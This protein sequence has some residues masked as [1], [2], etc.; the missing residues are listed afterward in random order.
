MNQMFQTLPIVFVYH[1]LT[2]PVTCTD[3]KT[4]ATPSWLL[5]LS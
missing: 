2:E 5:D 4:R 3:E 1:L